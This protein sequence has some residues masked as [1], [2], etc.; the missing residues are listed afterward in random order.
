MGPTENLHPRTMYAPRQESDWNADW[1]CTGLQTTARWDFSLPQVVCNSSKTKW[2]DGRV[3][4]RQD[5][6]KKFIKMYI[7]HHFLM[8]CLKFDK[9]QKMFLQE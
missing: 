2:G 9:I 1:W 4:L 3:A 5:L 7:K 6:R 8:S